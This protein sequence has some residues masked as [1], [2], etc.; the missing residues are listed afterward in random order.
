MLTRSRKTLCATSSRPARLSRKP[1]RCVRSA[2]W[3]APQH[4]S[5]TVGCRGYRD[6]VHF[7]AA[8]RRQP[9]YR[10]RHLSC[11]ATASGRVR[12]L[13]S[14]VSARIATTGAH[15]HQWHH[16]SLPA[17]LGPWPRKA[18][19]HGWPTTAPQRRGAAAAG[20]AAA[21]PRGSAQRRSAPPHRWACCR[22]PLREQRAQTERQP[23][24]SWAQGGD[25]WTG[26]AYRPAHRVPGAAAPAQQGSMWFA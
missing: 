4:A 6:W 22:R 7:L 12:L 21:G 16:C 11:H 24:A 26:P 20:A 17:V 5:C 25:C 10:C 2:G 9:A 13:P 1:L 23:S 19:L 8:E 3:R 15:P 18:A 14:W